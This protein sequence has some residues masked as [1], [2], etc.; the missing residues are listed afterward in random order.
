[1]DI[2]SV[3]LSFQHL[4]SLDKNNIVSD[5]IY[6]H[7]YS[8]VADDIK[9]TFVIN[10]VGK[11]TYIQITVS[12]KTKASAIKY[13]EGIEQKISLSDIEKKY[14]MIVSYD[15]VSEYYCNKT[16]PKLNELERNLR[17]LMFNTYTSQFGLEYYSKTIS[18]DIQSKGKRTLKLS[19]NEQKKKT[20]TIKSFFYSLDYSDIQS[21]LFEQHWTG[22]DQK[23]KNQFLAKN[24][25]LSELSNE[26]LVRA[27]DR[28]T[29]KSDWQRLFDGKVHCSEAEISEAI[30]YIRTNRNNV[31]HC[32][33]FKKE[34][35]IKCNG[36]IRKLNHK[37]MSAI[38]ITETKDFSQKNFEN[39]MLGMQRIKDSLVE[40]EKSIAPI[41]QTAVK[42]TPAVLASFSEYMSEILKPFSALG[43]LPSVVDGD[44]ETSLENE[45]TKDDNETKNSN[46]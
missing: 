8:L 3:Y 26:Q 35:Y 6:K 38:K 24:P 29:P 15:A 17:K 9:E 16:Y 10:E 5:S 27:F 12:G 11:G 36:E 43:Q 34:D 45:D 32:K 23:E 19:G 31:A 28:F 22:E 25:N 41:I 44:D 37:I 46:Q 21:I 7:T 13:L 20:E 42:T 2:D 40:F 33:Y 4:F 1:M 14:I 39:L 30:N 18:E